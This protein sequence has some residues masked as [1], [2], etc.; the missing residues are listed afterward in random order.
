MSKGDS[1]LFEGTIGG[2]R[3]YPANGTDY[4][5]AG[6]NSVR[7]V[8]TISVLNE[9]HR[10]PSYGIPNSVTQ[11]YKNDI[12]YSERYYD[13]NGNAYLDIDYTNHGNT[14]LHPDVPHEHT[15]NF[16]EQGKL[17]RND[18]PEGGIRR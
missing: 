6:S 8:E 11:N 9:S 18:P 4:N 15:I 16:D 12:L 17:T 14:K 13:E 2:D 7:C 5:F 1:G 3:I 10:I